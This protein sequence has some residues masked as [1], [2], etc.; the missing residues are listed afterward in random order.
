MQTTSC[1]LAVH[2]FWSNF[3]NI[4]LELLIFTIL[5]ARGRRP[6]SKLEVQYVATLVALGQ[7]GVASWN[8]HKSC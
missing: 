8:G 6:S 4:S 5:S 1:F 2:E 7:T 3:Y